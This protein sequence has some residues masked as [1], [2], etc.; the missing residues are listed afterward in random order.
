MCDRFFKWYS[1]KSER[2]SGRDVKAPEAQFQ[3]P[4]DKSSG[5][6]ILRIATPFRIFFDTNIHFLRVIC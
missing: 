1:L 3:G 4:V 2:H 6:A 5:G